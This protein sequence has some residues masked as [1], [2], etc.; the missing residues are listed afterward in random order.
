M[1]KEIKIIFYMLLIFIGI[2]FILAIGE[3]FFNWLG[4]NSSISGYF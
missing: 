2:G 3:L 4:P 1:K